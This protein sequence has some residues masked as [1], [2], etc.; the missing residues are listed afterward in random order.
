MW[1]KSI[2]NWRIGDT[3][4]LSIPF[5]WLL[6]DAQVLAEEHN[7]P[8]V[9]GGPAVDL[10]GAPWAT[11]DAASPIEPLLF[12]NPCATFT[13]HGCPNSC[14]FCAVPRMEGAFRELASWRPAPIV[15][16][17]NLLA[18]SRAHF[19]RVID[20]LLQFR[21]TDFNQ[22]LEAKLFTPWHAD[23]I[24]RLKK[25]MVRFALDHVNQAGAVEK[26]IGIA[27]KAG[28]RN[29]G[30]YVLVGHKDTPDDALGRLELVRSWD[31]WPNP[32]RFQPLDT[33]KKDSYVCPGWTDREL[34]RIVRYY[35]RLRWF[36]HIPFDDWEWE[37]VS[38]DGQMEWKED[39]ISLEGFNE[40][41]S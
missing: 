23:Q 5:S 35:S 8:V 30:V 26:A 1:P 38:S 25:P 40:E 6:G 41:P 37:P 19:E 34:R 24:A 4:Y 36:E 2:V 32:M 22:G 15:C 21:A 17:N 39:K 3:L 18:A 13:T 27:R 10:N 14:A 20:S 7:G 29:F 16:D 28:L 12:H 9:A 11:T 31:V 33:Q